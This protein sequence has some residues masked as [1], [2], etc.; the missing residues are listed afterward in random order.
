MSCMSVYLLH[1]IYTWVT[2]CTEQG[3]KTAL[4]YTLLPCLVWLYMWCLYKE[5]H[6]YICHYPK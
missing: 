1:V 3:N 4:L 6:T 5:A 2:H